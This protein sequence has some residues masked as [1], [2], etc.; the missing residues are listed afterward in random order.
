MIEQISNREKLVFVWGAASGVGSMA[1]QI[2]KAR[3]CKVITTVGN[4]LKGEFAKQLKA[5]LIINY[6][7]DDLTKKVKEFTEFKV[8]ML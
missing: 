7:E 8:S 2:A 5:D 4:T 6:K 3:G 1:I